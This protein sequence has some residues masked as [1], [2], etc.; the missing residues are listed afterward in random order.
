[1]IKHLKKIFIGFFLFIGFLIG[2]GLT[3][4]E[5]DRVKKNKKNYLMLIIISFTVG[6]LLIFFTYY[7]E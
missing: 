7:F 2:Y 4:E 3:P 5:I 1:M 6:I